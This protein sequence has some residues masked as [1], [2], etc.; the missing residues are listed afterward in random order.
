MCTA[1]RYTVY[2]SAQDNRGIWTEY[3]P[4]TFASAPVCGP[5]ACTSEL[6]PTP[7]RINGNE[8]R[9]AVTAVCELNTCQQWDGTTYT[10]TWESPSMSPNAAD[11]CP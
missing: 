10:R 4:A 7:T 1:T 11:A 9:F 6:N 2:Y 5:G 3:V 8:Y